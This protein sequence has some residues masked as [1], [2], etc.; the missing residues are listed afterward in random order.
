MNNEMNNEMNNDTPGRWLT[1]FDAKQIAGEELGTAFRTFTA[2]PTADH[3]Y[4]LE[5]WMMAYQQLRFAN[6]PRVSGEDLTELTA[7]LNEKERNLWPDTI[8][9]LLTGQSMREC[10]RYEQAQ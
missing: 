1:F 6:W 8:V 10:L 3:Y 5:M 9:G 4:R 2:M 7:A